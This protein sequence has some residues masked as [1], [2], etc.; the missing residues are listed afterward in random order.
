[1]PYGNLE[2]EASPSVEGP[3]WPPTA[4]WR[5]REEYEPHLA[6][7]TVYAAWTTPVSWTWPRRKTTSSCGKGGNNDFPSSARLAHLPEGTPASRP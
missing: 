1:M 2:E 4:P 5:K 7:D 6:I 3:G